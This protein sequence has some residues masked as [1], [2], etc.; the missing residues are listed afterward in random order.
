MNKHGA[1]PPGT[2]TT[3][4]Q[5]VRLST[6]VRKFGL[7]DGMILVAALAIA[8]GLHRFLTGNMGFGF[9]YVGAAKGSI[10]ILGLPYLGCLSVALF[11]I[12]VR[13]PRAPWRRFTSHPGAMACL[14]ASAACL[15]C[16]IISII[17]KFLPQSQNE[18]G[19]RILVSI[20]P[21]ETAGVVAGAWLMMLLGQRWRTERT[22]IDRAGRLLGG[23]WLLWG[24]YFFVVLVMQ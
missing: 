21:V 14:A 23:L 16:I 2:S 4:T 7:L 8:F 13:P 12:S 9:D 10:Y 22:W 20:W 24:V 1:L 5:P 17:Y 15:A 11:V 6:T 19:D 3:P 18:F